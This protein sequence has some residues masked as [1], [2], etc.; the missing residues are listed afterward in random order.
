MTHP[1]RRHLAAEVG[2][3]GQLTLKISHGANPIRA[4]RFL[5]FI[6]RSSLPSKHYKQCLGSLFLKLTQMSD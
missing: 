2:G 3:T 6:S 5:W 1:R 4:S